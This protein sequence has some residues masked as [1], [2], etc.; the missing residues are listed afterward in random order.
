M[1]TFRG[2]CNWQHNWFW[3]S[4]WGFES[5]PPNGTGSHPR[6]MRRRYQQQDHLRPPSSSGL[7]HHPLKVAARVRIP[8][9]VPRKT[10]STYVGEFRHAALWFGSDLFSCEHITLP[11][12]CDNLRPPVWCPKT[13]SWRLIYPGSPVTKTGIILPLGWHTTVAS[14]RVG[15]LFDVYRNTTSHVSG[16]VLV[17]CGASAVALPIKTLEIL[18]E[19]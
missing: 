7:G 15:S 18:S 1:L 9:G 17:C 8:L 4:Y 13:L 2:W 6:G 12:R 3:S 14:S 19:M 11:T 10:L 5:S 16:F